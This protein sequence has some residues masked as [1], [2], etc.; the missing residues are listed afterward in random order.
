MTNLD[1][2]EC[3]LLSAK[4]CTKDE[5]TLLKVRLSAHN[6][7]E[8]CAISKRLTVKLSG[9]V[10]K[11]DIAIHFVQECWNLYTKNFAL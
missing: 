11:A 10:R 4:D 6:V 5:V 1:D 3:M 9:V 8:L 7:P 2:L